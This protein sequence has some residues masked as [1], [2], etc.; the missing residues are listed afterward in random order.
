MGHLQRAAEL[1]FKQWPGQEEADEAA[2]TLLNFSAA[3]NQW[4]KAIEYLNKIPATSPRRGPA[5]LRAGQTLWSAYLRRSQVPADERPPQAELDELRKRAQEI[6]SQGITRTAAG[7]VDATLAAAVF[8]MAQ[9]AV[10]TNQPDKAIEWLEHPKVGPLTLVKAGSPAAARDPFAAETY[11]LALRA[12]IAVNPQ[13]LKK[14]EEVMDALEKQ[15]QRGGDAKAAENLT[16]I[17][18]SLGRELQ[19]HLQ[20]LRKK[21]QKKELDAV[22]KAFEVFLDRVT[23]R[24]AGSSFASLN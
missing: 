20:D 19:Q 13:Q 11:K 18:I 10:E 16:A 2:L 22:S 21:G 12:Y 8:A 24:E 14:A 9:I 1:I 15:V 3:Q 5:E 4:D 23:K 17:Y 7:N 6:L